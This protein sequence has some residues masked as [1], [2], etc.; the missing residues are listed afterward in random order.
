MH[1][2]PREV[3]RKRDRHRTFT[4]F[5]LGV[6]SPRTFQTA[7]VHTNLYSATILWWPLSCATTSS[8]RKKRVTFAEGEIQS[9]KLCT[10]WETLT[11]NYRDIKWSMSRGI[12]TI[13]PT[14]ILTGHELSSLAVHDVTLYTVRVR[15]PA[16]AGILSLRHRV[17][18]GSGAHPASYSMG[19]RGKAVGAW[20]W[21]LT[22]I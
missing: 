21:P 16:E 5:R 17:E 10:F 1:R 18:T 2:L 22:S 7:L 8:G 4:R 19:T 20:S 3:L 12:F 13:A 11:F 6:M 14:R 9:A 15:L